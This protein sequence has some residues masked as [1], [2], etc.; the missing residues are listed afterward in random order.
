MKIDFRKIKVKDYDDKEMCLDISKEIG[1]S[2]LRHTSDYGEFDYGHEIFHNGLVEV[3]AQNAKAI[4]CYM[5]QE[6]FLALI[7]KAVFSLLDEI[8]NPKNKEGKK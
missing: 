1:D 5:E 8:I 4:K 2:F 3:N 6:H 7:K